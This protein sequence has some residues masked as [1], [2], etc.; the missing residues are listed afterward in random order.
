[1]LLL[2]HCTLTNAYA[3][4]I[5]TLTGI[6]RPRP[7]PAGLRPFRKR[8]QDSH[9]VRTLPPPLALDFHTDVLCYSLPF[10]WCSWLMWTSDYPCPRT[11]YR[12]GRKRA[13]LPPQSARFREVATRPKPVLPI[14]DQSSSQNHTTARLS[15]VQ[16]TTSVPSGPRDQQQRSVNTSLPS[17]PRHQ[18]PSQPHGE[19][20]GPRRERAP[21]SGPLNSNFDRDSSRQRGDR[22]VS[23]TPYAQTQSLAPPDAAMDVDVDETPSFSSRTAALPAMRDNTNRGSGMYADKEASSSGGGLPKGPRAMASKPSASSSVGAALSPVASTSPTTPFSVAGRIRDRS[24]PPHLGVRDG[25]RDRDAR[26]DT[27]SHWRDSQPARLV[28]PFPP[29]DRAQVRRLHV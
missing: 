28:D 8:H 9:L 24:P 10:S 2:L 7:I 17:G 20:D 22:R 5:V 21:P 23:D 18:T 25:Y 29:M 19:I 6:A 14:I 16:G 3:L 27:S 26:Q 1:M 4:M 13:P 12:V 15:P 11:S